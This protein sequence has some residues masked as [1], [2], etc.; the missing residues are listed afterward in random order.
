MRLLC[1]LAGLVAVQCDTIEKESS[2]G[3]WGQ[4]R[5]GYLIKSID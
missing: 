1:P 4:K 2:A 5:D 3:G